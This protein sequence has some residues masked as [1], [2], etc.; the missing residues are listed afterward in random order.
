MALSETSST[1]SSPDPQ[2]KSGRWSGLWALGILLTFAGERMIGAGRA[3]T[4]LTTLGFLVVL[5]AM[6]AR[7]V[8]SRQTTPDRAYV[9]RTLLGLYA[10]G[11][12]AVLLYVVQSDLWAAAFGKPLE[13]NWPRLSTALAALWPAVW[14]VAA[15]PILLVEMAYAQIARAPRLELGRIRDAMLSGFGLASA[16]IFAF[17]ISYVASE[18]DKKVDLA[19]FR[20]TRPGEVTR[21]IVRNLDQPIEAALFFPAGSE[22][23]EEVGN[24]LADLAKESG[25]LKI[26]HYDY[27]LDVLKAKEYGVSTN[28][29][30]VFVRGTRHEQ[31]G[32]PKELEQ[33]RSPLKTLDKEVQQRLLTI[34]KPPRTIAFTLGHG[35]RNW[36]RPENDTD[37]RP[38]IKQLRD[39]LGDQ[40]YNTRTINAADG[41]IP[42]IP[43]DITVVMVIGPQKPF[44][45][46]ELASLNQFIDRGGRVLIALDPENGVDMHEVL[47]RLNLTF[48]P[49]RLANDQVFARKTHQDV[50]RTNLVTATY[51]SHPSVTTLSR[52]GPRAP[53]ILPGAGWI[54]TKRNRTG[55]I[56]VD[57]PIKAHFATFADK[58]G[59]FQQ[60]P[61]ED[62]RAWELGATAI[63]KD[64]RVFVLADSDC[65][66]DE[67]IG[68]AANQLLALDVTHWLMGDENLA[69]VASSEA[70]VPITH[71][72]KQDVI[73]FYSTIF[74]APALVI[75]AGVL[76]TR[77]GKRRRRP[78]GAA[79]TPAGGGA[80]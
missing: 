50:D 62:R 74:L 67:V 57:A 45:P 55:E 41:L 58:N 13:K 37:K 51:G 8:R 10:L 3:R 75:F 28:S 12:A 56:P 35:E 20:T 60:D 54:D 29:V 21:R 1:G 47:E 9:E 48:K 30:V 40:T 63:K 39:M 16:L 80:A 26:T 31:L 64:A 44:Q 36:E 15:W 66:D 49:V 76:V 71:T 69:G 43:K 22:V 4:V 79:A 32:L 70:D 34:I 25:Q 17:A 11:L 73:W 6:A 53:I 68:A 14:L 5:A 59:N 61:G 2:S 24:Y 27:D 7:F 65:L 46:E 33:A 78:G 19:Y 77:S 38:G 23:R 52:L 72:R 42:E 18:R